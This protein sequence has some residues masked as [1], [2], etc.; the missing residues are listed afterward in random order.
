MLAITPDDSRPCLSIVV[1]VYPCSSALFLATQMIL[2]R[3]ETHGMRQ[4]MPAVP[5]DESLN[6]LPLV[7][8]AFLVQLSGISPRTLSPWL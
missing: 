5:R 2:V 7:I 4:I 6:M 8:T 1:I 3:D